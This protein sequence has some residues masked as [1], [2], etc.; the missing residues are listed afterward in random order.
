[1]FSYG[2]SSRPAGRTC[3]YV[4]MAAL[5]VSLHATTAAAGPAVQMDIKS[6]AFGN[7]DLTIAPGTTV[8]WTNR[9][10]VPHTVTSRDH[11]FDSKA[12]DTGDRYSFTFG[13]VGDYVY[14]CTLHP[15]MVGTVH[16]VAKK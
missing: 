13:K 7:A 12:L 4:L 3:A 2:N 6:F 5:V 8:V 14:F 15:Q 16:V 9:D 11:T 10:E 1:M